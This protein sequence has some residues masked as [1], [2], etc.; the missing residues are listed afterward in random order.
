[1]S[2]LELWE[3]KSCTGRFPLDF[4]VATLDS[5]SGSCKTAKC[6]TS[7]VGWCESA[8]FCK[9]L[10]GSFLKSWHYK[11]DQYFFFIK[12][13]QVVV[14]KKSHFTRAWGPFG[15]PVFVFFGLFCL[16]FFLFFSLFFCCIFLSFCLFCIFVFLSFFPLCL[17]CI[18]FVF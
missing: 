3:C 15:P 13:S 1:M 4:P 16:F 5:P 8:L 7:A 12:W 18:F 11:I 6:R 17:F 9:I 14:K 2:S 10:F